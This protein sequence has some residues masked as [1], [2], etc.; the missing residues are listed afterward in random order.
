M[1]HAFSFRRLLQQSISTRLIIA[2]I[3]LAPL[4]LGIHWAVVLS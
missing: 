3:I 4:W 2:L 1:L